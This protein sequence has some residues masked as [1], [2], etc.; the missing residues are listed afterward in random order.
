M[1]GMIRAGFRAYVRETVASVAIML[2]LMIPAIIGAVGLGVDLSKAYLVRDRL[3]RALDQAALAAAASSGDPDIIEQR[4]QD[5]FTVNFPDTAIGEPLELDVVV[6]E[7]DVIVT[8]MADVP[9]SIMRLLGKDTLR[10]EAFTAVRREVRGIEVALVLDNTG[11]MRGS[12]IEALRT[13]SR[14]FVEILFD[15]TNDPERIRIAVVPY[16]ATVNV[17]SMAPSIVDNPY[18][19]PWDP[20]DEYVPYD[21][22]DP[23]AWKGCV[24]ERPYPD[25]IMDTDIVTG[26]E[27]GIFRWASAVDNN[28]ASSMYDDEDACNDRRTPNLGCPTPITP[29]TS[30]RNTLDDAIS[31]ILAWCRG[32]TLGNVGMAWGWRVLSPTEPFTEGAAYDDEKW[33]KAVVMMTDGD[34]LI[35]RH[36]ISGNPYDSDDT[37]Y[38]RLDDDVLGTQSRNTAKGIVDDRLAEVCTAMKSAGITVYTI[39]FGSGTS[40]ST[41]ELYRNCASDT[42]KYYDA[43]S[44]SDLI[45]AFETIS[46]EL[47][48]LHIRQ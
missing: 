25:D 24:K 15:R 40:G 41:E 22:D 8:A 9:M 34:N 30:D 4:L 29:L 7:N 6:T 37:A 20:S 1:N 48:N 45:T 2:G 16:S 28:W 12:K 32:G 26:G 46:R 19:T 42:G 13:A 11:S 17:G 3:G 35:Y 43:P 47:S 21:P 10:V 27:W 39:T 31:D 38:G 36:S 23:Y 44:Q 5:F 33:R 14:N 18:T